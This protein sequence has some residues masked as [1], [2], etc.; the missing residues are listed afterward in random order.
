MS[1]PLPP[2]SDG[3]TPTANAV[4]RCGCGQPTKR[5][6]GQSR[7]YVH[8][9]N[10]RATANDEAAFQS[11]LGNLD[12]EV[13]A[14]VDRRYRERLAKFRADLLAMRGMFYTTEGGIHLE[15]NEVVALIDREASHV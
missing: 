1:V 4:C 15:R 11:A 5:R 13:G 14:A 8:G 6:R 9:H 2:S 12:A 10:R 7:E 3:A